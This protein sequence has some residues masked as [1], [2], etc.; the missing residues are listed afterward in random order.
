[1]SGTGLPNSVHLRQELFTKMSPRAIR[2][3]PTYF[4]TKEFVYDSIFPTTSATETNNRVFSIFKIY[5]FPDYGM[6]Y[7]LL[8]WMFIFK[9]LSSVVKSISHFPSQDNIYPKLEFGCPT[10]F[11][12]VFSMALELVKELRPIQDHFRMNYGLFTT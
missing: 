10:L 8:V 11:G 2:W 7:F 6:M 4:D 12:E 1:M 5:S 3:Y 9:K